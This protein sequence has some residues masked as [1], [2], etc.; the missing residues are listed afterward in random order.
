MILDKLGH[1]GDVFDF[2]GGLDSNQECP[3]KILDRASAVILSLS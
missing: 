1:L 2:L 3:V